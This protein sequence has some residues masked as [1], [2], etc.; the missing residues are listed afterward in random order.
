MKPAARIIRGLLNTL[1]SKVFLIWIVGGWI[2]Y[3]V[4]SAIWIEEAFAYFV[5][6]IG[7]NILIQ[8]MFVL[9]LLCGYLNL[10]RVSKDMLKKG[11]TKLISWVLFSAGIM[12][13]CTGFF[14]SLASRQSEWILAG[15]GHV[16]RPK[17]SS[18]ELIVSHVDAGLKESFLDSGIEAGLGIFQYEPILTVSNAESGS[19]AIGAF[20]PARIGDTYY[21]ILNFGIA[22]GLRFS[23]GENVLDEG[24]MPL[25]ILPP[26][27]SDFF[28]IQGYPYRFSVSLK[29]WRAF[30]QAG[31]SVN[32]YNMKN[33]N[34]NVKVFRGEKVLAEGDPN[35][36]LHFEAYSLRFVEPTFWIQV[37]AVK[38]QGVMIIIAGVLF[39]ALGFLSLLVRIAFFGSDY[40]RDKRQ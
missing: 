20:P 9:F 36:G 5:L 10:I 21:H 13:F 16:V 23:E 8:F 7:K 39:T 28:E 2:T 26:G 33:P 31:V 19:Y 40:R 35:D 37:E 11:I 15:E 18:Q 29:A 17:W 30:Q 6:G 3:Y 32:E 12:V 34:Y 14:V 24:Y 25:R 4:L 38:D 22:P 27:N 1:S